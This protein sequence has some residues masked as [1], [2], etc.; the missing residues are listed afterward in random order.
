MFGLRQW[1]AASAATVVMA[2]APVAQAETLA[3]ALI[4]AYKTSHLL[5]QN[6]A[7]LRTADEDVAT[8]VA[9]LRPVMQFV[10]QATRQHRIYDRGGIKQNIDTAAV[11]LSF[12]LTLFDFGRTQASIDAAKEAVLA[13]RAGLRGVEQSVLLNTVQAYVNVRLAQEIVD[14]RRNNQRVIGEELKASQDRFDVGEVTRTDVAQAESALGAARASLAAAEGDLLVAREAYKALTG[15]YPGKLATPP[16]APK[17]PKSL[18]QAVAMAMREHPDMI[19]QQHQV[20]AADMVVAQ[21]EA[22]MKPTIGLSTRFG[23]TSGILVNE[24]DEGTT[25]LTMSHTLYAGGKLS[26]QYRRALAQ[27][28]AQRS[29]LLN[30]TVTVEQNAVNAWSSITVLGAQIAGN[31]R[32][33]EAAQVAFE[34]V[35]EEAKLGARTTLEVLDAEQD[36][37]DARAARFQ[38]EAERY[39]SYY[40]LLAAT[41]QLTVEKLNL[42]IPT[43]DVAA[44]YNAVK[45]APATSYQGRALDRVLK[46]IGEE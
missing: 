41:G 6:R 20:K 26:A 30:T 45:D 15:A 2:A 5:D 18:E 43:Y 36:L 1:L 34:G 21:A 4:A 25:S 38:T 3:D 42:G 9:G 11:A 13:T 10:A 7:L 22:N 19:Q 17:L 23:R 8:A 29:A 16:A 24:F 31:S 44:Y 32:Q 14:L 40:S 33:I 46:A 12:D 27:R 37:L 39:Y 28:E 35:R